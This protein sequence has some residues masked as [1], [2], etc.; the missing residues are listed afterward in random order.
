VTNVLL[1][2]ADKEWLRVVKTALEGLPIT[3][4][5]ECARS[6]TATEALRG[7][8][9]RLAIIDLF[10]PESSGLEALKTL[11]RMN[12][13]LLVIL[14]SRLYARSLL[15]KAFRHGAADVLHYPIDS[16]VIRQTVLHRLDRLSNENMIVFQKN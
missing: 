16:E 10:L 7:N 12:E 2:S 11:K 1:M 6:K 8:S 9:V 3:V 15:D 4:V 14:T 5:A 13:A